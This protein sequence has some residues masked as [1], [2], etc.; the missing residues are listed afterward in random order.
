MGGL[1][2]FHM[3]FSG[4]GKSASAGTGVLGFQEERCWD[5]ALH[6]LMLHNHQQVPQSIPS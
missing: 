2:L 3:F 6:M 1:C 4:V 5:V